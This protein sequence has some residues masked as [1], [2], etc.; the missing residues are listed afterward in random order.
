MP[1]FSAGTGGLVVGFAGAKS[2]LPNSTNSFCPEKPC[3]A[4][5][6][7]QGGSIRPVES[8]VPLQL[9]SPVVGEIVQLLGPSLVPLR[10]EWPVQ[11]ALLQYTAPGTRSAVGSDTV[12][13]V[14][15]RLP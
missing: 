12:S 8:A 3:Q 1:P 4:S 15:A 5:L 14:L 10:I 7:T 13:N 9:V 6:V 11:S 2:A